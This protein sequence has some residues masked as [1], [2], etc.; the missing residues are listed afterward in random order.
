MKCLILW[1]NTTSD[2][3]HH[4][5]IRK[6]KPKKT[7]N[8]LNIESEPWHVTILTFT[9]HLNTWLNLF[10]ENNKYV[11]FSVKLKFNEDWKLEGTRYKLSSNYFLNGNKKLWGKSVAETEANL[12]SGLKNESCLKHFW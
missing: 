3:I 9:K 5:K 1:T 4:V 12:K 8:I 7:F 11:K 2:G 6:R 10:S